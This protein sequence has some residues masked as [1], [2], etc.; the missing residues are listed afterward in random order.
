[1]GLALGIDY[2]LFVVSRFREERAA[3]RDRD[4]AIAAAGA[5]ASRAV[6]FSGIAVAVALLGILFVP[7]TVLRSLGIGATIVAGV[8]VLAALTL[9]P[10]L[11]ALLGD[12]VNALRVPVAGRAAA[13]GQAEGRFWGGVARRVMRRPVVSLVVVVGLLA[14]LAAP[15]ADLSTSRLGVSTLPEDRPARQGYDLLLE[16]FG[17]GAAFPTRIVVSGDAGPRTGRQVRRAITTDSR[18]G[19]PR[20]EVSPDG[21]VTVVEAPLAGDPSAT[22]RSMP[23]AISARDYPTTCS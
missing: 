23:S 11:L 2:S 7:D 3:G 16:T 9:L 1:M 5:T 8:S 18:F 6:L 15:V 4:Q 12:R 17:Y 13:S 10:A 19:P 21:A 14:A 20:V 22:R